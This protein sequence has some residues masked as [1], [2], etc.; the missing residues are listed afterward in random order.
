MRFVK[1]TDVLGGGALMSHLRVAFFC[2]S[3]VFGMSLYATEYFVDVTRPDDSGDGLSEAT[4]KHTIQAAVDLARNDDIVTVLPGVYKEGSGIDGTQAA[5]V[6]LTNRV[7]LRSSGG[8]EK[9]FIVGEKAA[10]ETGLGTGELRCVYVSANGGYSM[11]EGFTICGGA[12]SGSGG[13]VC[14]YYPTYTYVMDCIISNNVAY[15][16]AG[17]YKAAAV[18]CLIV[19]NKAATT[20]AD[21]HTGAAMYQSRAYNSLICR[22]FDGKHL[23]NYCTTLVNCTVAENSTSGVCQNEYTTFYNSI[24]V[25]NSGV[26]GPPAPSKQPKI[27]NCVVDKP[28]DQ[29]GVTN[30]YCKLEASVYQLM[31]PA[32]NDWRP[33]SSTDAAGRG[34]VDY[35]TTTYFYFNNGNASWKTYLETNYQ[36]VDYAGHDIPTSGAIDCGCIQGTVTPASGRVRFKGELTATDR[37]AAPGA[38]MFS[39]SYAYA[40]ALPTQFCVRSFSD[41]GKP[42]FMYRLDPDLAGFACRFPEM[43]GCFRLMAPPSGTN[44]TVTAYTALYELYVD[45]ARGLDTNG[46][47]S[48]NDAFRTIQAAV[49]AAPSGYYDY[50]IIHV[51]P[52]YYDEGGAVTNGIF[53]RV[54]VCKKTVR[55]V[56][57]EGPEKTLIVG[58]GDPESENGLGPNA[59]RCVSWYHSGN[60]GCLQGFTLTGGRTAP[61]PVGGDYKPSYGGAFYDSAADQIC[62]CIISNNM[63]YCGGMNVGGKFLRCR[64]YDNTSTYWGALWNGLFVSCDIAGN[65]AKNSGSLS[66]VWG[67]S[68]Y[69]STVV[70]GG[71]ANGAKLFG[72]IVDDRDDSKPRNFTADGC[73]LWGTAPAPAGQ[74]GCV[75]VSRPKFVSATDHHL[76]PSSPA[77]GAANVSNPDVAYS[78]FSSDLDG[79]G[80]YFVNGVPTAGVYQVPDWTYPEFIG[81]SVI[82]R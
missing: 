46:G 18:K 22:N 33:R 7:W 78:Y 21:K 55:I 4:A 79:N 52:G 40:E 35:D 62:D 10:T 64:I 74:T 54:S 65:T 44:I 73:A 23:L 43:D 27:Y 70:N 15:G 12:S 61:A 11:I 66:A 72:C 30:D 28:Q 8:K 37:Y 80:L 60:L 25:G 42:T 13:G 19:G 63:A 51:A 76:R 58:A 41:T 31:A 68:V 69:F 71:Y 67:S 2:A 59:V 38:E 29:F 82:V 39:S 36:H 45:K 1:N 9:T 53:N 57:D 49:D 14:G 34:S 16:G 6:A 50:T 56:A 24:I 77:I 75:V 17:L 47:T 26:I 5:R 20:G 32:F 48:T 3:C 81:T